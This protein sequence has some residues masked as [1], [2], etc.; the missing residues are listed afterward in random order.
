MKR[1]IHILNELEHTGVL[2][3]YAIGGAM[4]ALF[5]A[6]PQLTY[7]LDVFILLPST[8]GGL[9]TL[10]PLYETLRLRG[11]QEEGEC[12]LIEGVPVQFLPAY[13]ALLEEALAEAVE[14]PYEDVSTRVLR[15]E[16]LVAI[17]VQTGRAKDKDRVRLLIE[18]ADMD[19]VYLTELLERYELTE[20]WMLW[21]T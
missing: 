8:S 16:H 15:V 13:N 9:L 2:N 7:D 11:Y 14:K 21:T 10:A 17:C 3:R 1:T 19:I 12:V 4:G 5:Y 6:E 18:E 20:K